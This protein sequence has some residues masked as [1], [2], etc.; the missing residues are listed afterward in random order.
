MQPTPL[1]LLLLP[2]ALAAQQPDIRAAAD[3][4]FTRWDSTTTP[5]CAVGI[6]Q[7][8]NVLLEKGY[9]MADLETGTKITPQT[10]LESGSVA[11]QFTAAA[12]LL[13]AADGK[14][15]LD[16][17]VQQ[18]VPELPRYGRPLTIRHLLTHTSG[19]RDWSNLV[20]LQGWPRGERAH[21]Q[22]D[23]LDVVFRQKAL[24]YP[25]GD[26]SRRWTT[27]TPAASPPPWTWRIG[28]PSR[29]GS[30]PAPVVR[31]RLGGL[32]RDAP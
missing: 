14:L 16:D 26:S 29:P 32:S 28:C 21:T 3:S 27:S 7:N 13:L 25:V 24:N 18:Y 31:G 23:L 4:V 8:G 12:T 11:K 1:L 22:A 2:A 10:I 15:S 6:E 19:L 17:T 20:A 5:G 9:G 30:T